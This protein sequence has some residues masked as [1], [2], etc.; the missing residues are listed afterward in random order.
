[1]DGNSI[2]GLLLPR[3]FPEQSVVR[4]ASINALGRNRKHEIDC[5]LEKVCGG[6]MRVNVGPPVMPS[7]DAR[8]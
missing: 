3:P 2:G 6:D 1:V 5:P 8:S 4:G 7:M